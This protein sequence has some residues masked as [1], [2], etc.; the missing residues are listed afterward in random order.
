[1]FYSR[2]AAGNEV[3]NTLTEKKAELTFIID[4]TAPTVVVEGVED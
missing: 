1:M 4:N 2:D 3:N